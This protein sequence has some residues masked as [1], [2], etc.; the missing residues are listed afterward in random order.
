MAAGRHPPSPDR[1]TESW[2][3]FAG[4]RLLVLLLRLL[5]LLLLRLLLLRVL[6]GQQR[7]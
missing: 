7:Y 5:V 4:W 1:T 6:P 3:P 2:R